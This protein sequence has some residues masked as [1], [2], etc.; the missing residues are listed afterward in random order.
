MR[1]LNGN[2]EGRRYKMARVS[3]CAPIYRAHPDIAPRRYGVLGQCIIYCGYVSVGW[4]E[5]R[6]AIELVWELI[7]GCRGVQDTVPSPRR[8]A[9]LTGGCAR[10]VNR[11]AWQPAAAGLRRAYLD[12]ATKRERGVHAAS[13]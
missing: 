1:A 11:S 13:A 5:T 12:T 2:Q 9:W 3:S 8:S 7:A 10:S 6:I 4:Q